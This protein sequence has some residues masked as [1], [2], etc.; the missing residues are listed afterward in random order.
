MMQ[1]TDSSNSITHNF[2]SSAV[3]CD[4]AAATLQELEDE[5]HSLR[6][7]LDKQRNTI[8]ELTSHIR[9]MEL[10]LDELRSSNDRLS[11]CLDRKSTQSEGSGPPESRVARQ[12]QKKVKEL[13]KNLDDSEKAHSNSSKLLLE[14]LDD[15]KSQLAKLRLS[16]QRYALQLEQAQLLIRTKQDELATTEANYEELRGKFDIERCS[17]EQ[18]RLKVQHV[19]EELEA[20]RM[21]MNLS[22]VGRRR[23]SCVAP[24]L[25]DEMPVKRMGTDE[26]ARALGEDKLM[27]MRR[28]IQSLT[29]VSD[30]QSNT[31][32]AT[33]LDESRKSGLLRKKELS[34]QVQVGDVV[35]EFL[36]EDGSLKIEIKD[37]A[38]SGSFSGTMCMDRKLALN[39][40]VQ[41][42]VFDLADLLEP[43]SVF[44][45]K[46]ILEDEALQLPDFSCR[47]SLTE[48]E[49]E[50]SPPPE[51]LRPQEV[52]AECD[53]LRQE[54]DDLKIVL[55]SARQLAGE[56]ERSLEQL[57]SSNMIL[58][59]VLASSSQSG[60]A[61][62]KEAQLASNVGP[63]NSSLAKIA[64]EQAELVMQNR[65][66]QEQCQCLREQLA[67]QT[68]AVGGLESG[69]SQDLTSI[70]QD[71][72]EVRARLHVAQL[73]ELEAR[74]KADVIPG[75]AAENVHLRRRAA[76]AEQKLRGVDEAAGGATWLLNK[77]T[78]WT[79]FMSS[80]P[81][82]KRPLPIGTSNMA[83]GAGEG[84]NLYQGF[85]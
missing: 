76:E 37:A 81:E 7:E 38:C 3:G 15:M 8:G 20:E 66:L 59:R 72:H 45:R 23:G 17:A 56:Q 51:N 85:R 2:C 43:G 44:E 10:E 14:Q 78:F 34:D 48:P 19:E 4:L 71:A 40:V 82:T 83:A 54:R 33:P 73:A 35:A 41:K 84:G 53:S 68:K 27:L 65:A 29:D 39:S 1:R 36:E 62:S 80:A 16:E 63:A 30:G 26:L 47:P 79:S 60:P 12:F 18:L 6:K 5:N 46:K 67:S 64:S 58:E 9:S 13:M 24:E 42:L 57:R 61:A 28:S 69:K 11:Q 21:R 55:A 31:P 77:S 52:Q 49:E 74:R 75:L 32:G 70:R 50:L 22:S 25:G